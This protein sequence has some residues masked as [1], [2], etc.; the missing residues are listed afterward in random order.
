MWCRSAA[1]RGNDVSIQKLSLPNNLKKG[2]T[3][4]VKIF[5]QADQA[6]TATVRLYRNDQY[7]DAQQVELA[8][9]K[10]LFSFPQTLDEPG[11]YSY[12]IQLGSAG[13]QLP[14]NN[15]AVNFTYVRGDPT[16]LIVSTDPDAD[17]QL[18]DALRQ[19]QSR[20][21]TD[22][23]ERISVDAGRDADA[24]TRSFSATLPRAISA[25]T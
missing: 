2:Q 14:Q 12:D 3:F 9:G 20:S 10:N 5:A 1:M 13:D 17:A 6:Q 7:L 25:P 8:A 18:A 19:S 4:D 21:E 11:F 15:R 24:T 16:I 22:R 23:Y